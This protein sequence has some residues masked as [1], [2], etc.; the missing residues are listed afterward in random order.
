MNTK[1]MEGIASFILEALGS[2]DDVHALETLRARVKAFAM[3][4]Y[5]PGLDD[6]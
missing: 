6:Y 5:M 3:P 1:N 2:K 4:F